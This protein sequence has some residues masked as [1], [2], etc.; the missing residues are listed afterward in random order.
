MIFNINFLFLIKKHMKGFSKKEEG[1]G[2][3]QSPREHGPIIAALVLLA[4]PSCRYRYEQD[5]YN[6]LWTSQIGLRKTRSIF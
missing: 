5:M 2:D 3:F 6:F 4:L 1:V